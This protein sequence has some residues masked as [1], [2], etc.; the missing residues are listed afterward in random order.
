MSAVGVVRSIIGM[1]EIAEIHAMIAVRVPQVLAWNV[2]ELQPQ[3]GQTS[4]NAVR[5]KLRGD[6]LSV[7]KSTF[8][9][10]DLDGNFQART[11]RYNL[12]M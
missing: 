1:T 2:R 5:P 6:F 8:K 7:L 9:V 10:F 3:P 11:L 4:E 12:S